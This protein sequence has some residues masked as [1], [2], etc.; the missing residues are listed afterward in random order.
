MEIKKVNEYWDRRP[1]NIKHSNKPIGSKEYFDEVEHRKYFVEYHIP[2]FAEFEKWK[3][4]KVLEIGCG[5][6]TDSINFARAGAD[7]TCVELSEESLNLC[8]KR[9]EVYG[10]KADFFLCNAEEINQ[11]IKNKKFDLIYSFGVIHHSPNPKA[12]LNSIKEFCHVD[13]QIKIMVYSFIS[14]KTLEAWITNGWRFLFNPRKSIQYYAEAQLGC[15]V[16]YTYSQNELKDLFKCYEIIKTK[17]EH[18]FPYIIK[19]YKNH[20]YIK[21]WFFKLL[22]AKWFYWLESKLGWHWL[23]DLKIK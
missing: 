8:K 10:L 2:S 13:T 14:Y 5:I 7:L 22:P 17:K 12:I 4:K 6:G 1:C 9:F 19:H 11:H 20:V 23:I 18:I 16:A 21:R 3:G 15:P